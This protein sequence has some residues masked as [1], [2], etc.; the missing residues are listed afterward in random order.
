MTTSN[1]LKIT[2]SLFIVLLFSSYLCSA[3]G[4][5]TQRVCLS[6]ICDVIQKLNYFKDD[7]C[8]NG[9]Y[10]TTTY[11]IG[12]CTN[13]HHSIFGCDVQNNTVTEKYFFQ[14]PT[15]CQGGYFLLNYTIGECVKDVL[16]NCHTIL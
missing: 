5:V 2:L 10:T 12:T 7:D 3:F 4:I 14:N 16:Y 6:N 1:F 15:T 13:N 8:P 9:D 11:I